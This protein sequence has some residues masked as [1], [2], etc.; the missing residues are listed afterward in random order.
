MSFRVDWVNRVVLGKA[1][2]A[3]VVS[4]RMPAATFLIADAAVAAD[5]TLR[6]PL[7]CE[8]VCGATSALLSAQ[9][10]QL[11]FVPHPFLNESDY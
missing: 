8:S 11:V 1:L 10:N 9:D 3:I 5:K 4:K 6:G 2:L 7:L